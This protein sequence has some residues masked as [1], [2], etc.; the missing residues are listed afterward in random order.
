MSFHF[1]LYCRICYLSQ[2]SE[3]DG[4]QK[5]YRGVFYHTSSGQ[6]LDFKR[7]QKFNDSDKIAVKGTLQAIGLIR[8]KVPNK[9]MDCI[10]FLISSQSFPSTEIVLKFYG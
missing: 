5:C 8:E 2:L 1:L 4:E 6:S 10:I 9:V 7:L 3:L